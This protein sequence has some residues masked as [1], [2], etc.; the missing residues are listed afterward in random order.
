MA[1]KQEKEQVNV[2]HQN[3]IFRETI[4]KEQREQKLYTSYGVNPYK[5]DYVLAGKP[6][7]QYDS[8]EGTEDQQYLQ[9]YRRAQ[10]IPQRKFDFPQTEAQEIGWDTK[11][12]INP[13]R[14]DTRLNNP[15]R[16]SEITK[17]MDT[18]W[19]QKEQENLQQ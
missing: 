12:L 1:T 11:P 17:Y 9:V 16:N 3:A 19:R 14:N 15:R 6:N 8:A 5:K 7:S 18:A 2:V 13:L 10:D 4:H